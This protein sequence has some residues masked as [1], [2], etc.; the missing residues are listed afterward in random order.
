MPSVDELAEFIQGCRE[1]KLPFKATAGLHHA[2]R[3][4]GAHGFVNLLAAAILDEYALEEEDADAFQLTETL[5]NGAIDSSARSRSTSRASS[6]SASAAAASS[7]R[8]TS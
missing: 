6:S 7:S 2:V 3:Q 5:S 8:S 4:G 1:R